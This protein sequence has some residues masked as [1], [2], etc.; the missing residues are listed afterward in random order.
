MLASQPEPSC[1]HLRGPGEHRSHTCPFGRARGPGRPGAATCGLG[2]RVA[3][4]HSGR[5]RESGEGVLPVG[6]AAGPPSLVL[7][8]RALPSRLAH[9]GSTVPGAP[10]GHHCSGPLTQSKCRHGEPHGLKP[11]ACVTDAFALPVAHRAWNRRRHQQRAPS[12]KGGAVSCASH[13]SLTPSL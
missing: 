5:L 8:A 11:P 12:L 10:R 3:L 4:V 7:R 1:P 2:S 13:G 9:R 6:P